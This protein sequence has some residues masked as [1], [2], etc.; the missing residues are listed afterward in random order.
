MNKSQPFSHPFLGSW[1]GKV[2]NVFNHKMHASPITTSLHLQDLFQWPNP[3]LGWR[4]L[5]QWSQ[6]LITLHWPFFVGLSASYLKDYI[7]NIIFNTVKRILYCMS[8]THWFIVVE[9]F[10]NTYLLR[11]KMICLVV[12]FLFLSFSS[13]EKSFKISITSNKCSSVWIITRV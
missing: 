8:K 2:E 4:L 10:H 3:F 12:R 13:G 6:Q 9:S 1:W 5:L 7:R 11:F